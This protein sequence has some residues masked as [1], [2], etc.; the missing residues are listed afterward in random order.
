M[1]LNPFRIEHYYAKHE[2]T[3]KY[4]LSSSDAES[5]SIS[6][7]LAL[8]T[9]AQENF[10]AQWCGYTEAPGAPYLRK[11][12]AGIY[13]KAEAKDVLVC[14]CAEEGIYLLYHALLSS[15][16]HAIIETPC[17]ESALELARS[18]GAE[19]STWQ[20]RY[21]DGWA[22]DLEAL[23][24][25]IRPNTKVIYINTPSNPTGLLMPQNV[26]DA[27]VNL[28]RDKN[29]ILFCD[30][31]YRELEHDPDTRLP[32][33]CDAYEHG[34]S[35]GSM[36]KTY[37]LPGLRLGWFASRNAELLEKLLSYKYY[38][39]ICNSAPSEFLS[40]L[41]LRHRDVFVKRNLEIV[42]KNLP[43]LEDFIAR[44]NDI[45]EWVKP[46]ASPIGFPRFKFS[47]DVTA[48][49][50]EVVRETSVLLLPGS[51]YDEPK[52]LRMGYGRSNM[53][54]ALERLEAYLEKKMD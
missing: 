23:E 44:H 17:Y 33:V 3:A 21:E 46:N 15:G 10:N 24:G 50:E 26:F 6:E 4:M 8:E 34:V 53:P 35:L 19:V 12:V 20:R 42:H 25:L 11:A 36:S 9:G 32:A 52:H 41:A 30:E 54:E 29:I 1:K 16:D 43:L 22:H 48:F 13:N 40:A 47:Q 28:A 39:T 2:F 37:G 14:S 49:C 27:V 38:T 51:V 31:V 5:R 18:T 45:F 7:L